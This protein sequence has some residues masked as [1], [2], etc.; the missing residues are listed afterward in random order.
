MPPPPGRR[1]FLTMRALL[2]ILTLMAEALATGLV[3]FRLGDLFKS[4]FREATVATLHLLPEL[5]A[6]LR[7]RLLAELKPGT[8]IVS[9]QFDIG[10][11]QPDKKLESNGRVVYFWTIPNPKKRR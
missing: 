9:H 6:G 7:P 11:W 4:D 2:L 8:W 3:D 10:D 5:N 1:A